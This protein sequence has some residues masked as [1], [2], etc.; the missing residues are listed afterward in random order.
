MC[1]K[2]K[3]R[4]M[5]GSFGWA[6]VPV[7][8]CSDPRFDVMEPARLCR[9]RARVDR[10]RG[11]LSRQVPGSRRWARIMVEIGRCL[12][13]IEDTRRRC[14]RRAARRICSRYRAVLIEDPSLKAAAWGKAVC[15]AFDPAG[16]IR[17]LRDEGERAGTA[18][19]ITTP[20]NEGKGGA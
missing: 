19:V 13:D 15:G 4:E 9:S 10:L 16:F 14:H 7:L 3:Q 5:I 20:L 6:G 2:R 17:A 18:V 8:A 1:K 12:S 11:E